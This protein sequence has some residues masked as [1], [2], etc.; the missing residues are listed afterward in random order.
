[1][2]DS[3][4]RL[5]RQSHYENRVERLLESVAETRRALELEQEGLSSVFKRYKKIFEAL[6]SERRTIGHRHDRLVAAVMCMSNSSFR[7]D[8]E[9]AAEKEEK[10][11]EQE[12]LYR[13]KYDEVKAELSNIEE[14]KRGVVEEEEKAEVEIAMLKNEL[15]LLE[16]MEIEDPETFTERNN[17]LRQILQEEFN[18][19]VCAEQER[20]EK[21][22]VQLSQTK[23]EHA[24]LLTT[25]D[26]D[27]TEEAE[28]E[29]EEMKQLHEMLDN[30][31]IKCGFLKANLLKLDHEVFFFLA[32]CSAVVIFA[33]ISI[34][35]I[36]LFIAFS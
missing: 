4:N 32:A 9:K 33:I 7:F 23:K 20:I 19:K 12:A 8:R 29:K 10:L 26:N 34:F 17:A 5:L 14:E 21:L 11:Q 22:E 13:R 16:A 15:K 18:E 27:W 30:E 31:R 6:L 36:L 24:T 1:M 25:T 3:L 2:R 28:K 35:L